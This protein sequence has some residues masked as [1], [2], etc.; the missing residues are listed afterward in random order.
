[1]QP[2]LLE[3]PFVP[4]APFGNKELKPLE[5]INQLKQPFRAFRL[6]IRSIL[7]KSAKIISLSSTVKTGTLQK[8]V[9]VI[10]P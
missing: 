10:F 5:G 8:P 7:I 3:A 1:M 9:P 2:L 6:F 4:R